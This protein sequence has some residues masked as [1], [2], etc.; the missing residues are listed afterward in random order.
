MSALEQSEELSITI[1]ITS[2]F[3][4][5]AEAFAEAQ[6][7]QAAQVKSRALAVQAV[8]AY[9]R[10][11]GFEV[12]QQQSLFWDGSSQIVSPVADVVIANLGRL[13]CVIADDNG[14]CPVAAETWSGRVG[15]V[16][17]AIEEAQVRL[18]GFVRPFP[19]DDP[20]ERVEADALESLD[21]LMLY[22]ER[23][24]LAR[25]DWA[26]GRVPEG[27]QLERKQDYSERN[28]LIEFPSLQNPVDLSLEDSSQREEIADL[29]SDLNSCESQLSQ[30]IDDSYPS[31]YVEAASLKPVKEDT[32]SGPEKQE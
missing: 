32:D 23:L 6:P 2:E 30:K 9:M 27:K 21:E 15:Y 31:G 4:Q 28:N 10:W 18:L 8:E 25:D 26:V 3:R 19:L 7:T 16:A 20:L 17:V 1:P 5:Q 22:L 14:D 24:G 12:S 13:E 11:Q 29:E